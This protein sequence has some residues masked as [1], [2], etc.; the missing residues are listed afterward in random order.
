MAWMRGEQRQAQ[1]QGDSNPD[2]LVVKPQAGRKMRSTRQ[3]AN[4][5]YEVKMWP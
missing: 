4:R 5:R 3:K 1:S 2:S